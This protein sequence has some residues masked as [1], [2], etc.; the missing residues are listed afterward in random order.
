[1]ERLT[2][3]FPSVFDLHDFKR[4]AE[5]TNSDA[6]VN[7]LT[8]YFTHNQ[9]EMATTVYQAEIIKKKNEENRAFK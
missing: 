7:L 8:A 3:S 6:R 4:Q 2:L 9:L 1:M 5:L